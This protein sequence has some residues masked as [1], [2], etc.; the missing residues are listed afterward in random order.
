MAEEISR[1]G[2]GTTQNNTDVLVAAPTP[3]GFTDLEWLALFPSFPQIPRSLAKSQPPPADQASDLRKK[4]TMT[5]DRIL[6]SFERWPLLYWFM[7]IAFTV[8]NHVTRRDLVTVAAMLSAVPILASA[9]MF[10]NGRFGRVNLIVGTVAVLEN[11]ASC[12]ATFVGIRM[13]AIK[14]GRGALDGVAWGG[15]VRWLDLVDEEGKVEV[16]I[17]GFEEEGTPVERRVEKKGEEN[18]TRTRL[19]SHDAEDSIA[20]LCPCPLP[21]CSGTLP[22]QIAVNGALS[23][24]ITLPVQLMLWLG[25]LWTPLFTFAGSFWTSPFALA[26]VLFWGSYLLYQLLAEVSR[27]LNVNGGHLSLSLRLHRR[28]VAMSLESF[29][30]RAES[31]LKSGVVAAQTND[32]EMH[33]SLHRILART[34][35]NRMSQNA[36]YR[37]I[38]TWNLLSTSLIDTV[39]FTVSP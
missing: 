1:A 21:S 37:T 28:A 3:L 33:V 35:A 27:F 15:V 39:L 12:V 29:L 19:I 23:N 30:E 17:A 14:R 34:W 25:F 5:A 9:F 10:D 6:K 31:T 7:R 22:R 20:G 18:S 16:S 11:L 8:V 13:I 4:D 26:G 2:S 36:I 24:L 32:N 38:M